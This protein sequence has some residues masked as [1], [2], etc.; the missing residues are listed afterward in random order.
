MTIEERLPAPSEPG[1]VVLDIGDGLGAAVIR[2]AAALAG[3][4][5][6]I[7]RPGLPWARHVAVRERRMPRGPVWAAV[8]DG[9]AE[10]AWEVRVKG[11]PDSPELG[12]TVTGGTVTTADWPR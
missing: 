9:L 6:E 2:T 1:S 4:E 3:R 11:D 8:F 10:G 7:R 12:V 5:L